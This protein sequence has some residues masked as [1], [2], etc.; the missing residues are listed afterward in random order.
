[1]LD[2]ATPPDLEFVGLV[3]GKDWKAKETLEQ[4][5]DKKNILVED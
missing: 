2:K 5:V 4:D 1:M 3:D